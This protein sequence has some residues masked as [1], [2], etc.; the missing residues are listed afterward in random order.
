M[1]ERIHQKSGKVFEWKKRETSGLVERYDP[2]LK[3]KVYSIDYYLPNGKRKREKV[4]TDKREA[5]AALGKRRGQIKEGKFFEIEKK[6]KIYLKDMAKMFLQYSRINK[7]SFERDIVLVRHLT[8]YFGDKYLYQITPLM[9][10]TYRNLRLKD[11]LSKAT[12]N[13]ET[14]ALKC[15]FNKAILWEKAKENPVRKVKLFQ[16]NN[17]I[18]RYLDDD[19]RRRL[20]KACKLSKASHLYPIVIVALTTGMRKGEILNLRWRD[21][22]FVNG[23][24]H[25]EASKS[26]K[27]RD[28]P[29]NKLLT[30]T[31]KYG[32]NKTPNTEYIF[33]DEEGKPFTKLETSF[34]NALKR[35]GIKNFRFHDTRHTFASY[36]V[37]AGVDIYRVSKLLGHSSVR[38]TERY[39]HLS[40]EYGK[41]AVGTLDR[42]METDTLW[43][44]E[45][46]DANV[47]NRQIGKDIEKIKVFRKR[48]G[49]QVAEGAGLLNL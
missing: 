43:T 6:Q 15:L 8:D 13:R 20:L 38:V 11:G 44:L 22:D 37:M 21:V 41:A 32:S 27:R 16:E 25:I 30:E 46:S 26:G 24:V 28:I 45:H 3:K 12:I 39:S 19:E 10:E 34:R 33:S 7:K 9:V 31:L 48:R 35:A 14:A 1:G 47:E 49:T 18:V 36:L 42:R 5:L 17:T 29:M 40:P 23:F 4:G 2:K